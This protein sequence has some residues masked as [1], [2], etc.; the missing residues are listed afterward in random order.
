M[1]LRVVNGKVV[2]PDKDCHENELCYVP[3]E[4]PERVLRIMDRLWGVLSKFSS[5]QERAQ[6]CAFCLASDIG[7]MEQA[8]REEFVEALHFMIDETVEKNRSWNQARKQL[9]VS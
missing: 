2:K 7:C 3:N 4:T 1:S 5:L 8:E 6:A 9:K